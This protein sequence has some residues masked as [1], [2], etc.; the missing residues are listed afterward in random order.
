[1]LENI[2]ENCPRLIK[3][4]IYVFICSD[5]KHIIQSEEGCVAAQNNEAILNCKQELVIATDIYKLMN[6]TV[7][8]G[9]MQ[10]ML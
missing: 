3:N 2:L 9:R 7:Y 10:V 4:E 6:S 8:Y 1:M 5:M